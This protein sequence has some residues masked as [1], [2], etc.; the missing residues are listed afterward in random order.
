M[1]NTDH[2][3]FIIDFDST[4]VQVE[5]LDELAIVALNGNPQKNRIVEKISEITKLGMEGNIPFD[6]SLRRRVEMLSANKND[7]EKLVGRL[8]SKISPS[9][10]RNKNFFKKHGKR[11]IILSGGF[12][13]IVFPIV[14]SFG[15]P[16]ENIFANTFTYDKKGNITG[17]DKRN[18][19]SQKGGKIETIRALELKGDVYVLG[20]G[21]TDYQM[22]EAGLAH[23]F[24]AFTENISRESVV[25]KADHIT[26]NFDEFLFAIDHPMKTYYPK[27]RI[28]I[29]L[30]ENIQTS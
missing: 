14:K 15:I 22:K 27:N 25:Q 30:L 26:P 13:E 23:K 2:L 16:R 1:K 11:I 10:K 12:Q 21:Y 18:K 7:I 28:K 5:T 9:I 4:F 20:D 8:G 6:E 24:F 17:F 19:L 29:L 3:V